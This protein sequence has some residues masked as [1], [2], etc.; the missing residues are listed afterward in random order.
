PQP[1]SFQSENAA[2]I[3]RNLTDFRTGGRVLYI[4]SGDDLA[5]ASSMI[6]NQPATI[7]SFATNDESPAA[8]I[9]L[10]RVASVRRISALHARS[11]GRMDFYVLQ[12]LPG[13]EMG[14]Q[15]LLVDGPSLAQMIPVGS[16][17]SDGSGRAAADFPVTTGRYLVVKWTPAALEETP[18][19]IAEVAAFGETETPS[20]IAANITRTR[21]LEAP[22]DETDGKDFDGKDFAEGKDFGE[23]KEAPAEAPGEGPTS[24]L[25]APPPF[26]FIPVV[27]PV[28]P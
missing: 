14:G 9:D 24:S 16:V 22:S 15:A 21:S 27:G 28:S 23:A 5:Q 12:A 20:L 19:S 13:T 1:V 11:Q 25:P 7:F 3:G 2:L 26:Q 8:I 10:G 17:E 4:T 18:F 6:D